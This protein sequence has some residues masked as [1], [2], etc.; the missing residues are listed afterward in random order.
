MPLSNNYNALHSSDG[1]YDTKSI[2]TID[3]ILLKMGIDTTNSIPRYRYFY[4][5]FKL[6]QKWFYTPEQESCVAGLHKDL[7]QGSKV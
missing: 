2:D 1:R 4:V 6:I 3:M 5:V 7:C